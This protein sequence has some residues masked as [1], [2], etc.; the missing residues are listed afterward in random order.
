MAKEWKPIP[1]KPSYFVS[2]AGEIRSPS[3]KVLKPGL[4]GIGYHHLGL[5]RGTQVYVHR[6]VVSAFLGPIPEGHEVNHKNG[7]KT[8]NRLSNLEI[9]THSENRRHAWQALGQWRDRNRDTRGIGHPSARLTEADVIMIR[10]LSA[11]GA[12][13]SEIAMQFGITRDHVR[14]IAT[15]KR[16][17]HLA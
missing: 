5:G 8:D 6:C 11:D 12:S 14:Q 4:A 10:G 16:W 9:V 2:D 15:R 1:I 3:G 13:N 17:A 7:V